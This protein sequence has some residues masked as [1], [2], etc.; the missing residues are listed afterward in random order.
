MKKSG[1]IS[2]MLHHLSMYAWLSL[3][4][5]SMSSLFV[6][7]TADNST[8]CMISLKTAEF[9]NSKTVYHLLWVSGLFHRCKQRTRSAALSYALRTSPGAVR[10]YILSFALR[11]ISVDV[12]VREEW[13][14]VNLEQVHVNVAVRVSNF[15][16]C[17]AWSME[18]K[19]KQYLA[20]VTFFVDL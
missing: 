17:E 15:I 10:F 9:S 3:R 1:M 20:V 16:R 19:A 7:L 2:N 8:L 12:A 4:N 18:I 6:L 5:I 14:A 11:N 13:L